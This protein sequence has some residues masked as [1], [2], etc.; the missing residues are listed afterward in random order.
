[1]LGRAS[2]ASLKVWVYVIRATG[3]HQVLTREMT[4]SGLQ[5]EKTL[6]E[7]SVDKRLQGECRESIRVH[8][9]NPGNMD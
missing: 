3:S 7:D 8:G 6:S 2:E 5:F 9:S 1:M 4:E